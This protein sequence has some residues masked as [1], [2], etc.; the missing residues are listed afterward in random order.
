LLDFA[1]SARLAVGEA[2]TN[3][4]ATQIGDIKRIKLSA[5]WM[6]AAGHPGEDAGLY[7]AVKAV[8][9]ELCPQ[10]GL[11]IP[12]G[13]D[14]MSMKTRWQEGNEQREMTSPLS[15]VISA[16][17]RVEDVRHT[18]TPQL[19]TEDNALLLIDLGK[20][21]NALGATAL[22]QVYR[23]LGD[24]PADV[25]DVAQLKGFYDAMQA[26][27]AARKLLAWHDRSD[28]GLLVTLAEM[29]FA[30]HCGVQVDIAALGD[31]HL[32]A[33]FNEE[34][35]GVI[36]V[37]AEDRDA[38]EAL[39]AQYGLADCVHYLGQALAGDR[40]VITANDRTVFSESRTT[41]RVWWA[42]TTW[43]MQRLRDNPQCADQEHEAKANDADPGLNVKLSFDI[44]EDIAAPYIATGARPKVAVLREQGVNSH[45][46]MAAAFHRA[47]FDAIDV[48]MSD[49]LGGRIGLGNFHALVACGG[50][51][52][53]DVLGA[54]EG[55]AKSI[56]FNH[57]VRDEFET[58]FHRPQTL[59]LG[60]C[61]GCQM[62]SNLREL[63]P[64]SELWPRF[65]RNHSDRFE[66]RFSL[67]EVTQ[68]PSLLLQG[69]VGSQMPIAVS[70]GE[71][72]VEVR[73][74][75]HLAA[76]ESKGLVALRY[77]DN[78]GHVTETYPANPNGSPNG[79]TAVTTENG[80]VT[81]MMPHPERV[82]RT[83]A[84]SWHPENW[85]EDSPWMR[86]FRNA[87]KQ[88]G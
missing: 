72:R 77:V 14:S 55:W 6:A 32:A 15:L 22:A 58:F 1:A 21:H 7:D 66:A 20:G 44:N 61:N 83:V 43:Q 10:L 17:A 49:L 8:G 25:R 16:F 79:I 68:S 52:Y 64:G 70:H 23:Q 9:E 56:L 73:D 27:V 42:E 45:V 57:R 65:V 48:H 80:R 62:M 29:A 3:I 40:F 69:M 81:I 4:A 24:K 47:G 60:V 12:V 78:F 86:I 88:L 5:N 38:V 35:G 18:L 53:G 54:G 37:R 11:T 2:L 39:L 59:A 87:R 46:E 50:F 31:D 30:G 51:S 19:S 34:L 63:I 76:L 85:G 74:D 82:F 75:A 71:G 28:G 33:L 36:Q 26:L 84:N 41:L 67:V 13:K